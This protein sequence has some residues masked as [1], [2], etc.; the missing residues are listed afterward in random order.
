[1]KRLLLTLLAPL[2]VLAPITGRSADAKPAVAQDARSLQ[3]ELAFR[4]HPDLQYRMYGVER[5]RKGEFAE[6][7]TLLRRAARFGDKPSQGLI[8]EMYATGQGVP[9]DAALAYAWM[10]LAA[11]R[12]YQDFVVRR[13][14]YWARMSEAD[15]ARAVSKGRAI[16]AEYGDDVAKPRFA[17]QLR[18]ASK[19]GVGSRT[20]FHGTVNITTPLGDQ[21]VDA[22]QLRSR[23]YW[24][25]DKY[26]AAQDVLWKNP[27]GRV[28]SGDL[29]DVHTRGDAP[30]PAPSGDDTH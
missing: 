1:M 20:G 30:K 28:E 19:D 11:E 7:M 26:W 4:G 17:D 2:V 25:A 22:E 13:E 10:D 27:G 21:T 5:Y 29:Q 16:Y 14:R 9:V 23:G 18:K 8:A 15:R 24:D 12:G 6:A 3:Y